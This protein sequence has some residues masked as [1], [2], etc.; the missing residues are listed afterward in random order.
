[1]GD[2]KKKQFISPQNLEDKKLCKR[3]IGYISSAAQTPTGVENF[4]NC[5]NTIGQ[6]IHQRKIATKNLTRKFQIDS[7]LTNPSFSHLSCEKTS[8]GVPR[9]QL[10][11]P[12]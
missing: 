7:K 8:V 3:V 1:M 5:K 9:Y 12:E 4:N 2:V 10:P 6:E 11:G